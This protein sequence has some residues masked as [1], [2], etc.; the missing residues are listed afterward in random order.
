MDIRK[1]IV[2]NSVH[3]LQSPWQYTQGPFYTPVKPTQ[4]MSTTE[5][6]REQILCR[7]YL[8]FPRIAKHEIYRL[9][10]MYNE[11]TLRTIDTLLYSEMRRITKKNPFQR[12]NSRVPPAKTSHGQCARTCAINRQW[13]SFNWRTITSG[14]VY[15]VQ[16]DDSPVP[17]VQ[18]VIHNHN[19]YLSTNR[20][21][22]IA[23]NATFDNKGI[24]GIVF[25]ARG[26]DKSDLE[27]KP[28]RQHAMGTS[29]LDSPGQIQ[30]VLQPQ[31]LDSNGTNT[32]RH[33]LKMKL[34]RNGDNYSATIIPS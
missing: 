7:L 1:D 31:Q 9:F 24:K 23:A 10:R 33:S 14:T 32:S 5:I 19:A 13:K 15:N 12:R 34:S 30:T 28:P 8:L 29:I 26:V 3:F 2:S 25:E 20:F 16:P 4:L 18:Q 11:D 22:N 6:T 21:R 27:N 17:Q